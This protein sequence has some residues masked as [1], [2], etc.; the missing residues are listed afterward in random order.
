MGPWVKSTMLKQMGW[1]GNCSNKL[2][3]T[4]FTTGNVRATKLSL[5]LNL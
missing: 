1:N 4:L 5:P 3:I 2:K